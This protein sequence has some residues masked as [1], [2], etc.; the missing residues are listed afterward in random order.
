[1]IHGFTAIFLRETLL[2]RRRL[3]KQIAAA[4]VSPLLYL[5]TFGYALGGR[6]DMD[7]RSYVDFLVPGLLAMSS[8]TQA[9]GMAAEI[10]VSRFYSGVFEEIQASP[11]SR[12]AYVL[13]EM[14]AGLTRVAL[15]C[16]VILPLGFLFGARPHCGAFL[17]LGI[18]L[19]GFAFSALAVALAMSIRSHAD[20]GLLTTFVITP[21]A[22]LGGTFFPLDRLP[23][24]V[25][26]GLSLLPLTHAS[27]VIRADA[28][29]QAPEAAS[30]AVLAGACV[31]FFLLA[32][33][34]VGKARD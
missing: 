3:K 30:L 29:G 16:A 24:Y 2:L 31:V 19:N 15:A 4:A 20:Q 9:F 25:R 17:W 32:M 23:D 18:A 14:C 12:A 8:M 26:W 28:F 11:V 34:A 7:D 13:G 33:Y 5:L 10:N 27:R 22:F 1:M 21:M 6:L